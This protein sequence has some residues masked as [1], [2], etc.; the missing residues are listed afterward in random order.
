MN[1]PLVIALHLVIWKQP[2]RVR[3][4]D[5]LKTCF[6]GQTFSGGWIF[7]TVMKYFFE[8]LA[9]FHILKHFWKYQIEKS[10]ERVNII[11]S[12]DNIIQTKISLSPASFL[13]CLLSLLARLLLVVTQLNNC[14]L[15]FPKVSKLISKRIY[16]TSSWAYTVHPFS[17]KCREPS[18]GSRTGAIA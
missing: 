6:Y 7:C 9:P 8:I 17:I 3:F 15:Q 12:N 13:N 16:E 2:F 5:I 11:K 18:H 4:L 14:M 10:H 1:Y